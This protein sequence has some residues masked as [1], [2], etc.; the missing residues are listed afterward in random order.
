VCVRGGAGG[1]GWCWAAALGSPAAHTR[2]RP[3]VF[4]K[5]GLNPSGTYL[6][7]CIHPCHVTS[8]AHDLEEGRKEAEMVMFGAVQARCRRACMLRLLRLLRLLHLLHLL[9]CCTCCAAGSAA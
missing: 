4:R 7:A 5:S 2:C 8:P 9:R 6:P 3:Q 1:A